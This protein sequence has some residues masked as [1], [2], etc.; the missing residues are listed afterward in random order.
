MAKSYLEL[1]KDPRW[2]KKRLEVLDEREWACQR[3]GDEEKTLHVHHLHYVRGHMPWEYSSDELE[4][5]CEVC[6]EYTTKVNNRLDEAVKAIRLACPDEIERATGYL[7]ALSQIPNGKIEVSSAE[8]AIGVAD[9]L[10][11]RRGCEGFVISRVV[12]KFIDVWKVQLELDPEM[13]ARI[14]KVGK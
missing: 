3:C 11:S 6:H 12:D 2:Q 9:C 14:A 10:L 13:A 5:L 4:V 7:E 8:H 1:L